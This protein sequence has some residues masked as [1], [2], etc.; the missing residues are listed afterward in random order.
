[1]TKTWQKNNSEATD[2]NTNG[3]YLPPDEDNNPKHGID[4]LVLKYSEFKSTLEVDELTHRQNQFFQKHAL[5]G[6]LDSFVEQMNEYLE[7]IKDS[8]NSLDRFSIMFMG[9]GFAGT[10]IGAGVI[11][12]VLHVFYSFGLIALFVLI[13]CLVLYN[14]N[15]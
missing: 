7:P 3:I 2:Y 11:G 8:M 10:I 9:I 15:I 13:L 4:S 1:M 5:E 12:V 14:N 6:V